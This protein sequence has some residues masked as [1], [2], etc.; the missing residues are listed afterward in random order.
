MSLYLAL[1]ANIGTDMGA[2]LMT[3][4]VSGNITVSS[5]V[6]FQNT[7]RVSVPTLLTWPHCLQP[8]NSLYVRRARLCAPYVLRVHSE[9]YSVHR[10]CYSQQ[11]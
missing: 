10:T 1:Q 9:H 3:D 7:A 8:R 4:Q 11:S 2:A 5:S 6:F